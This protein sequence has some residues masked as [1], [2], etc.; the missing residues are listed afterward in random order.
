[1]AK[2]YRLLDDNLRRFMAAQRL[3]F[4]ATAAD[5]GRI[6]LSPK[7]MDTLRC[8]DNRTVAYLDL[9]GSGNETA[10]HLRQNGR[11]TLMFCSFDE[12]PLILRLY[13]RGRAVPQDTP[14]W[15]SLR[16]EFPPLPGARQII[17]LALESLQTSCGFGVPVYAFL[18]ERPTL[19]DWAVK[20]G[21]QGIVDYQ[22]EKNRVSIDGLPTGISDEN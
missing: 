13:G 4:T 14:E 17:V 11:M 2:F 19:R 6:N 15:A 12:H 7:G 5:S 10:A 3:F 9:T 8:L 16:P 1:M 21:E 18:R 22:R 20:K